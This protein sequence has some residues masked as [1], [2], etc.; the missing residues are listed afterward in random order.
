MRGFYFYFIF[1][2]HN[3]AV[4]RSVEDQVRFF[5]VVRLGKPAI[6]GNETLILGVRIIPAFWQSIAVL[7]LKRVRNGGGGGKKREPAGIFMRDR[8]AP[9]ELMLTLS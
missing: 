9:A 8:R 2:A 1:S 7:T 5:S 6:S 3:S 4:R